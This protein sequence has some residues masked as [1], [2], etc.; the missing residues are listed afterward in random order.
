M[1]TTTETPSHRKMREY[2]EKNFDPQCKAAVDALSEKF[3][4]KVP[5]KVLNPKLEGIRGTA[6]AMRS[7][8]LSYSNDLLSKGRMDI[9]DAARDAFV[10]V[11]KNAASQP[12][13]FAAMGVAA[14]FA[15]DPV[16]GT[17]SLPMECFKIS[18]RG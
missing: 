16:F 12:N 14:A 4:G 7:T 2:I 8:F 6:S 13:W 17:E 11:I 9:V 5:A 18:M 15:A 1:Q 3:D 10:S